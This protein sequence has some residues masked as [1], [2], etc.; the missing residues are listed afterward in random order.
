MCLSIPSKITAIDEHNVATV[1]TMGVVRQV[2][3][4][5][6]GEPLAIGDYVLIHV[7]FAMGKMDAKEA[8]ESLTLF[9]EIAA[10]ME[11]GSID[12]YEGDLGLADRLNQ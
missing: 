4:D 12:E 1:D 5:L 6:I 7:G 11:D 10:Q 2:S 8:E 9:R 3:L